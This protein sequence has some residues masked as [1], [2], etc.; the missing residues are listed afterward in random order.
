MTISENGRLAV[1]IA[2]VGRRDGIRRTQHH[3]GFVTSSAAGTPTSIGINGFGVMSNNGRC[4][5]LHGTNLP[6]VT[7]GGTALTVTAATPP[8]RRPLCGV[9]RGRHV[10]LGLHR[11]YGR[12]GHRSTWPSIPTV[13]RRDGCRRY[14]RC[15]GREGATGAT[16]AA[17][18]AGA[19]GTA[20]AK[21]ATGATRRDRR[22]RDRRHGR[23]GCG[24]RHRCDRGYGRWWAPRAPPGP[25]AQ[26]VRVARPVRRVSPVPPVPSARPARSVRRR[27]A[28]RWA[29][30]VPRERLAY[31]EPRRDGRDRATGATGIGTTGATGVAG[32]T[33]AVGA[34]GAIGASGA[35]GV[36][37]TGATGCRRC[38]GRR[39]GHRRHGCR[40]HRRDRYRGPDRRDRGHGASTG[41]VGPT[42]AVGATGL[43]G[44]TGIGGPDSARWVPPVRSVP[45]G[46]TGSSVR[47]V[48]RVRPVP[49]ARRVPSA[50]PARRVPPVR[51]A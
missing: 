9:S 33:G 13:L 40:G 48:W 29:Q 46:A 50:P 3:L 16:G 22:R 23:D 30:P 35:T 7:L 5:R 47:R 24:R 36:G 12:I 18:A 10:Y 11:R 26:P 38:D 21:G 8:R 32:A 14:G 15:R 45:P 28:V 42:G 1:A 6:T 43:V 2:G 25:Q 20:G 51:P 34:T 4:H 37:V 27:R 39:R 19:A 41:A 17:G 31:P 44:A 49:W